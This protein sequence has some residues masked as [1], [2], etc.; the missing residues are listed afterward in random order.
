MKG[1]KTLITLALLSLSAASAM[2][3]SKVVTDTIH[4]KILNAP[5]AYTVYL[6]ESF[7]RQPDRRFPVLYLLH[8]MYGINEDWTG[9]GNL[10]I[11]ADR[12]MKSGEAE[13][14]VI[15]TP[16]AGGYDPSR[17]QNGYFDIPGWNYE[18]FFFQEFMPEIEK[19]Y[20]VKGDRDNRAI[21]GLS[22][23]GGGCTSYAQRHPDLFSS[24]YAMSALMSLDESLRQPVDDPEGKI[25]ALW[26]SAVEK[27]CTAYVEQADAKRVDDLK[28]IRWYVDCG[29]DDFLFDVNT[30]FYA[31]MRAK[32]IPC[33]F[34]VRDG[35]HDWEYWHTALYTLLPFVSKTFK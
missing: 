26:R 7:D 31:A 32:G 2:A 27:S 21:A 6:P 9:Q 18:Q 15:V 24:A 14:M 8:G 10:K 1:I 29:D 30:G 16:D 19:R 5:R 25:A 23:G 17:Q 3:G 28:K 35:G 34:R 13:E 22:M 20:R 11:V 4:S 33:E 12:L